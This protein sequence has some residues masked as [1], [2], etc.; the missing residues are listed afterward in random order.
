M[1]QIRLLH[2]QG[3]KRSMV[4]N[5][6]PHLI[7]HDRKK[8]ELTINFTID[9]LCS[10]V[11]H[12]KVS[13]IYCLLATV[14][15][16]QDAAIFRKKKTPL[17][18]TINLQM[19]CFFCIAFVISTLMKGTSTWR[20][21]PQLLKLIASKQWVAVHGS[22]MVNEFGTYNMIQQYNKLHKPWKL[23]PADIIFCYI[24]YHLWSNSLW[25][26]SVSQCTS[27]QSYNE[28][29]TDSPEQNHHQVR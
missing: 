7:S 29:C 13:S 6:E 17:T 4:Y 24:N 16:S 11:T 26:I 8:K 14:F 21:N 15:R 20:L 18:W 27:K 28:C 25:C 5:V 22:D 9:L 1:L 3:F 2:F 19:H 23:L 12:S 10:I